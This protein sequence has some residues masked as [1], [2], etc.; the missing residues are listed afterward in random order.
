LKAA[1]G[2]ALACA[3]TLAAAVETTAW[4]PPA[5]VETRM[6][7]LQDVIASR[8][9]TPE[10]R[11][12]ARRE[13]AALLRNPAARLPT[14]DE[15][16]PARAAIEPYPRIVKPAEGPV[17]PAAPVAHLEVVEPPKTLVPIPGSATAAVP[18]T[19]SGSFAIDPRTGAVLHGVPGGYIDPRTGQFVPR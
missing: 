12:A 11:E 4:P 19:P 9:A 14:P 5:G 18:A 2:L 10:Q 15:K 7:E 1:V 17:P 16:A 8:D 3:A 13:L 6:H